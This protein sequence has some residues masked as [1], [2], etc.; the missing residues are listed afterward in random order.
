MAIETLDRIGQKVAKG[1]EADFGQQF[2]QEDDEEKVLKRPQEIEGDGKFEKP[3]VHRSDP[4][5]SAMLEYSMI[6]CFY[7]NFEC[8]SM[9]AKSTFLEPSHEKYHL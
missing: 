4:L 1:K 2:L 9:N 3:N 7:Q 8:V 6:S 5:R